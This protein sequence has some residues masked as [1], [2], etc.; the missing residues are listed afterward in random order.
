MNTTYLC[1]S[2]M[3][4]SAL[5]MDRFVKG[6]TAGADINLIDLEDAVPQADKERARNEFLRLERAEVTGTLGLRINSLQTRDGLEDLIAVLDSPTE[7]DIIVVPKV[8]SPHQI[9]HVDGVLGRAGRRSRLWALVETPKGVSDAMSIATCSDRLV[10]LTFGLADYAAEMGASME[11]EAM[12]FARSQVV[13]AARGAGIDAVDAPTF[14]L[15]DLGL[16][17]AESRRSA[18]MGFSGKIA[19]HPRQLPV[20]NE[21]YSPTAQAVEWAQE[22]VSTFER[23]SAGILTVGSLMVGPP[24][25]KKARSILALVEDE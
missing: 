24:F 23:E 22:V 11:W 20:I 25:L 10:A 13:T 16:L 14:D 21:I 18:D 8:E 6:Q 19:I 1:R 7:P 9:E 12:L 15:D 3:V 17:R 5:R 4:T 2:L